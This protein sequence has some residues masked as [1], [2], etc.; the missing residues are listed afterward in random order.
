MPALCSQCG[1]TLPNSVTQLCSHHSAEKGPDWA[2]HN[3][4][5]CDFIHR[6]QIRTDLI[7]GKFYLSEPYNG[8]WVTLEYALTVPEVME[9]PEDWGY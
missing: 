7:D 4:I 8:N 2:A 1:L 3:K 9:L 6:G 5:V